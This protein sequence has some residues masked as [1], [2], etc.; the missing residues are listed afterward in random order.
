ML[1][2]RVPNC[3]GLLSPYSL[4]FFSK[5]RKEYSLRAANSRCDVVTG[6]RC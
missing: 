4:R 2:S 3:L 1:V 5:E 6:P